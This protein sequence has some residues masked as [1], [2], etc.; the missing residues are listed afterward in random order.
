MTYDRL[1]TLRDQAAQSVGRY[2]VASLEYD[3][4]KPVQ[5]NVGGKEVVGLISLARVSH[6]RRMAALKALTAQGVLPL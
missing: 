2:L 6:K 1:L 3:P 4:A 5:G